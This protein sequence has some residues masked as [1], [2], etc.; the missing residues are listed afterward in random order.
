MTDILDEKNTIKDE[1]MRKTWTE[2]FTKKWQLKTLYNGVD[3]MVLKEI[4]SRC[5]GNPLLS[6]TLFVNLAQNGLLRLDEIGIFVPTADF[7]SSVRLV[8][9]TAIPL[10]RICVK[11]NCTK[12]DKSISQITFKAPKD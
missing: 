11:I 12:I 8:D 2:F 5:N 4:T 10:P 9:Y 1:E 6:L 3:E 7:L